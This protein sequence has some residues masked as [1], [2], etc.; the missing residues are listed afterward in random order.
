MPIAALLLSLG[1]LPLLAADQLPPLAQRWIPVTVAAAGAIAAVTVI[2]VAPYGQ[3]STRRLEVG[4]TRI[5]FST[6]F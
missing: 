2:W 4:S 1:Y 3:R 5:A 6:T